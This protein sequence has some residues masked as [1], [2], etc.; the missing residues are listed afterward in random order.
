MLGVVPKSVVN[1]AISEIQW[2]TVA[3]FGGV[4]ILI[5]ITSIVFLLWRGKRA[6]NSKEAEIEHREHL[7][8]TMADNTDDIFILFSADDYS[9][10]YVSPNIE[11]ILGIPAIEVQKNLRALDVSILEGDVSYPGRAELDQI[12]RGRCW[13][14]ERVRVHQKTNE[15]RWFQESIYRETAGGTEK[16]ILVLE[17]R[18]QERENEQI[19]RQALD[20][21]A[22]ANQA[23]SVFLANMSHD[24]RTPLGGMIGMMNV[25]RENLDS[26]EKAAEA[27]DL[28]NTAAE[29]VQAL[30]ND[31]LDMSKIE[32]GQMSLQEKACNLDD[33]LSDLKNIIEPQ[34]SAKNQEFVIDAENVAHRA[35]IGDPL[36]MKQIL[37][38]LLSNAVK[39]TPER[40]S[41]RFT[42]E[43][44]DQSSSAFSRLRFTVAD[45]GIGMPPEFLERIF[46]PFERSNQDVIEHIQGTGLGMPIAKSLVE[47]MG[48]AISV[49]SEIGVGSTFVVVLDLKVDQD[50][51]LAKD[52]EETAVQPER[53][54]YEGKRFLLAEDNEINAM[55][56]TELLGM[57]GASVDWA[58]D[59]KQAVEAFDSKPAGYYD[60]VFMDVQM[61]VMGGYEATA[62]IRALPREDAASATIIALTANAFAEDV[63]AALEAGMNAHVSKP[64]IMDDLEQALLR[65]TSTKHNNQP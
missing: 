64:I 23:K 65:V 8:T 22:H 12:S 54:D 4:F 34:A 33:I 17:D 44:I 30:I 49:E 1:A 41:I 26:K 46:D 51:E 62:A 19:L 7:F 40:G 10:E 24:L 31:I 61:P 14:D 37:L 25:A 2:V 16:F 58:E 38:N 48:G 55:V 13:Q 56:F 15:R 5:G 9:V 20:I 27:L 63:Q 42:V 32:S 52:A 18:T 57:R 43:E 28:A 36:H 59:G 11:R 60:V 3:V 47:A 21:A 45:T 6:L 29:Q 39:Y 35:L 50:A 53:Y